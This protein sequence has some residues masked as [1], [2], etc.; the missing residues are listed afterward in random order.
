MPLLMHDP[1][2][3]KEWDRRCRM[4]ALSRD[5]SAPVD[6]CGRKVWVSRAPYTSENGTVVARQ[7]EDREQG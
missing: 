4:A 5:R 2:Y 3:I 6:F 7:A 1:E